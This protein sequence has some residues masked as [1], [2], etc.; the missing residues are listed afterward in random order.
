MHFYSSA[1]QRA[2]PA[3][4]ARFVARGRDDAGGSRPA[5]ANPS[6][7]AMTCSFIARLD[8]STSHGNSYHQIECHENVPVVS[9]NGDPCN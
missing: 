9:K 4:L 3:E 8:V 7:A 6:R 1:R 2:V 5:I